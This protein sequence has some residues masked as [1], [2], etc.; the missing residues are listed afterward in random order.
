M[1]EISLLYGF[2]YFYIENFVFFIDFFIEDCGETI[3][4]V[5][6]SRILVEKPEKSHF[7]K[8]LIWLACGSLLAT[9]QTGPPIQNR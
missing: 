7:R 2:L 4:C 8:F 1:V 3:S 6:S 9:I 5:I